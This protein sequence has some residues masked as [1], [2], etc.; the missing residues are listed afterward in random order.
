[1]QPRRQSPCG[2]QPSPSPSPR[3]LPTAHQLKEQRERRAGGSGSGR[4]TRAARWRK[5]ASLTT[6]CRPC[7][8]GEVFDKDLCKLR[9]PQADQEPGPEATRERGDKQAK[10]LT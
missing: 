3:L 10:L 1:M 4:Y 6:W 9:E 8:S 5:A 7:A 2:C